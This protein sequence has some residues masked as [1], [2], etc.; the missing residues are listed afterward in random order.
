MRL[1]TI[2]ITASFMLTA[3]SGDEDVNA[4]IVYLKALPPQPPD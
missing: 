1:Q 4:L 2:I 3:R